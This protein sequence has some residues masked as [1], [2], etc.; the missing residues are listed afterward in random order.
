MSNRFGRLAAW[1]VRRPRTVI[2]VTV[3]VTAL[4]VLA[5]LRLDSEAATDTLVDRDSETFAATQRFD[6]QFGDDPVV[7]LVHGQLEDL[8]LT[9]NLGRLLQLEG[10]LAGQVGPGA[11]ALNETCGK[12]A[13]LD[14][15]QVVFGPATFLNQSAVGLEQQLSGQSQAAIEQARA[16]AAAAA[17]RAK[18][19]GLSE[20][21]QIAAAR[22]AGQEVLGRFQQ[23]I[24]E[25]AV[26]TG[27]TGPPRIDDPR[28]VSSI[29]FDTRFAGG[30][31]KARFSDFFPNPEAALIAVRLRPELG[32]AQR[33][34]AIELFRD[35]VAHDD[36]RLRAG[37]GEDPSYVVSGVPVVVEGLTKELEHEIF[38]LLGVALAVMAVTLVIVFGPPLR[39]LPLAV[40]LVATAIA[41][42]GLAAFGG[43]LTMASLAVLPVLIG[44]AVDYAIQFQ[45]RFREAVARRPAQRPSSRPRDSPPRPASSSCC[46]PRSRWCASSVCCSCS[47]SRSRSR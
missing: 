6:E 29:V 12:I 45:A 35:A 14:P 7:I 33:G 15:T 18:R 31:P 30:V 34:A 36:F 41:F 46:C 1:A 25:L 37:G 47:A 23:Q 38:I 42:G 19:Q 9:D 13:D 44:L 43:S 16:A 26:Q 21:D 5:A 10:C 8:L 4:G 28:F 39:L 11:E 20:E 3:L 24:L 2:A 17:Q 27:Q 32:E 22:G 40:A